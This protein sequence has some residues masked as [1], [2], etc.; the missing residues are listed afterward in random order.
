MDEKE[1]VASDCIAYGS[2]AGCNEHCPVLIAGL[3]ELQDSDNKELYEKAMV[4]YGSE[5]M[6]NIKK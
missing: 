3:C 5:K 6:Y 4:L 1:R 2:S